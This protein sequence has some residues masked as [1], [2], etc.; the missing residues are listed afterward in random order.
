MQ[1]RQVPIVY[2]HSVGPKLTKWYRNYLTLEVPFFEDQLRHFKHFYQTIHLTEYYAIRSNRIKG[3]R[4]P[5][6][7][8]FDDGYLDNWVWA[9]PLLKKYGL[10]ATI[11]VN[12]EFVDPRPIV[13]PNLE[14]VWEGKISIKELPDNAYLSWEELKQ[15]QN[16]GIIDIQSHTMSHNKYTV[17]DQLVDIHH[18]GAD[19]LYPIGIKYP[20]RKPYYIGNKDFEHLLPYGTPFFEQASSVIAQRVKINPAFEEASI[21]A[22]RSYNFD[23]YQFKEAFSCIKPLY[24]DYRQRNDLI[25]SKESSQE[26]QQRLQYEIIESK[27][28]LEQKLN[29]PVDF[30]CWPH[31]DNNT[32]AHNV[33]LEAGYLATTLG[34]RQK[35]PESIGRIPVRLGLSH[36]RNNRWLSRWKTRYKI[37]AY[38]KR[39]PYN[40]INRF[41][42]F[43]KGYK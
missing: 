42:Y 39:F 33:A 19:A 6:V 10:K 5:L 37:G 35:L 22:L 8:T 11:F 4:N 38:T 28:V 16:S 15:M 18:P 3:S 7:I 30:L 27:I 9:F 36:S 2:Y 13:R 34:S 26:Y 21:Y 23:D 25:V 17:S 20:E 41:Y 12:P 29:K 40:F 24:D 43:I 31:G 1:L 14:A 32:T